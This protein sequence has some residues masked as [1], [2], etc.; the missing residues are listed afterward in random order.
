MML[1]S[2][3]YLKI[4]D[5]AKLCGAT[6]NTLFHYEKL[7]LLEPEIRTE[8]GYRFYSVKQ[9][10]TYDV[11]SILKETGTSLQEIK[12][13]IENLDT[14]NF[15]T[16]LTEKHKMLELEHERIKHMKNVLKNTI[17]LTK[18]TISKVNT[19]PVIEEQKEQYLLAVDFDRDD[20]EKKRME[21]IHK[22]YRHCLDKGLSETL[23][24]G[25][26]K[27][28]DSIEDGYFEEADSFFCEISQKS[29]SG[30]LFIKPKGRYAVLDHQGPYDTI[31]VSFE[32]LLDY[33]HKEGLTVIGNAYLY[34]LLGFVSAKDP[35]N[36]IV[37][38]AIQIM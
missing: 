10:F 32:R 7:G 23:T 1:E 29:D 4:S 30:M 36:Y 13:Y 6:K 35:E 25:F 31:P 34:E 3:R 37:K 18:Q 8:N 11:I 14:D 12:Q 27:S 19:V 2:E 16:L 33:I 20:N 5:F 26:I 24:S 28:K 21:K 17:R 15:I 9:S 38:I 22:H